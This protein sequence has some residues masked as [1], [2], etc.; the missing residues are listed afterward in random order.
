MIS[1]YVVELF[2]FYRP[3]YHICYNLCMPTHITIVK[4]LSLISLCLLVWLSFVLVRGFQPDVVPRTSS[5]IPIELGG[6]SHEAELKSKSSPVSDSDTF[7]TATIRRLEPVRSFKL[8]L[9]EP[10]ATLDPR[11]VEASETRPA[12][13]GNTLYNTYDFHQHHQQHIYIYMYVYTI[14]MPRVLL[15]LLFPWSAD[16]SFNCISPPFL[17]FNESPLT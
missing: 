7:S 8:R 3:G 10:R 12:P 15:L 9:N 17:L 16:M 2:D 6:H 1:S 13:E 11:S 14:F 5:P 4:R